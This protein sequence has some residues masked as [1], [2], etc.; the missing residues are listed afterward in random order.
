MAFKYLN[1]YVSQ[2]KKDINGS[3]FAILIEQL[4]LAKQQGFID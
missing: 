1:Q 4:K 2:S 3:E